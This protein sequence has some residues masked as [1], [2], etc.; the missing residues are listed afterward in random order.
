MVSWTKHINGA[1]ALL[2]LRGKQQLKTPIGR[3]LF[4]HLRS[5]VVSNHVAS[6]GN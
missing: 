2:A 1:A 4:V 3:Q 5:Q 6:K